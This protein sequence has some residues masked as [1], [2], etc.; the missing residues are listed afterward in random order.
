M[1]R[2][3]TAQ[4]KPAEATTPRSDL[5]LRELAA[6]KDSDKTQNRQFLEQKLMVL[7]LQLA[8]NL[9]IIFKIARLHNRTNAALKQPV[10][11]FMLLVK[12]LSHDGRVVLR[13]HNDFLYLGDMHL[14]F[15]TQQVTMFLEFIDTLN[16][17]NIG[18]LAFDAALTEEELRE[19]AYLFVRSDPK[20]TKPADF[21]RTLRDQG[22]DTIE[23]EEASNLTIRFGEKNEKG[24]L[25]AIAFYLKALKTVGE[26][27]ESIKGGHVPSFRQAKRVVQNIVEL[28]LTDEPALLGL[29][30]LRCYKKYTAHHSVNVALLSLAI[31]RRAGF[32]KDALADL[33]LA[34]L[35][36]DTGKASLPSELLN[37][38]DEFTEEERQRMRNHP[39]DG[40]ITQV[41]LR[42]ID[43]VSCRIAA[44]ALEHH[45]YPDG[46]GYP[47]LAVPW[48]LSLTGRI[49]MIADHYDATASS[50]VYG[51]AAQ[52]PE[53]VLL[54][55]LE[56]SG[57]LFDPVLLK[58]FVNC[59]G[60][61]PIGSLVLLE[62]REFAVVLRPPQG[63][64]HPDRPWVKV[65]VD[66]RGN[67]VD[68][69]LLDLAEVGADG[70]YARN[71]S[72]VLD[73]TKFRFDSSKYFV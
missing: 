28:M 61:P 18:S 16:K 41:W 17:R 50:R 21:T 23:V 44:A 64:S 11:A 63:Q 54:S 48:K 73:N 40:V 20:T 8:G 32:P 62:S 55:M 12:N 36:H 38:P 66:A 6:L 33:G 58:L 52:P 59:I 60:I 30:T 7:A 67:S 70:Q 25:L 57:R 42:G 72:R 26:I 39:T 4:A 13:L 71:I 45:L 22:I 43:N 9:H 51:R 69:P 5:L 1:D 68:G 56:Q 29:T 19:F 10:E 47:V 53:K 65:I 3:A 24:K 2:P 14:K 49:V 31:A 15:T 34:A 46:S 35:L 27:G 37:K